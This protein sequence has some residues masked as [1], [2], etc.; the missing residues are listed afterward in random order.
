MLVARGE[1]NQHKGSSYTSGL[2]IEHDYTILHAEAYEREM[3]SSNINLGLLNRKELRHLSTTSPIPAN[4]CNFNN[5][6]TPALLPQ[7]T[8][9]N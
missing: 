1:T 8:E 5:K 6:M 4:I 7:W 2:K 3:P 9:L